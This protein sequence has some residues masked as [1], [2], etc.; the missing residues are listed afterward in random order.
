MKPLTSTDGKKS[1]FQ[2]LTDHVVNVFPDCSQQE[3]LNFMKIVKD[4]NGGT[5]KGLS[6]NAITDKIHDLLETMS[7]KIFFPSYFDN[8]DISKSFR[9]GTNL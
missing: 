6:F 9:S 4:R 8:I 1:S 2:K 7:K 3:L 5:L